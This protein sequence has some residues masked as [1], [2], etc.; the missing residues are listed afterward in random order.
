MKDHY[1]RSDFSIS[2]M[3]NYIS[4]ELLVHDIYIF[5]DEHK[6]TIDMLNMFA[7]TKCLILC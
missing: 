7:P 6:L 5:T 1:A 2:M 4:R 3:F